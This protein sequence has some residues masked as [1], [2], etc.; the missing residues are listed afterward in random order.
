MDMTIDQVRAMLQAGRRAP[1][2]P[3]PG[4]DEMRNGMVTFTTSLPVPDTIAIEPV[5]LAG[6]KGEKATPQNV[7]SSTS[8]VAVMCSDHRG[9][10]ARWWR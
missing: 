10:T 6:I 5:E 9:P 2:A 4:V 3:E 8:M 7:Q 1:D